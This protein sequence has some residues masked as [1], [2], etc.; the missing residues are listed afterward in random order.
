MQ[1]TTDTDKRKLLSIL[2]HGSIFLS[3]LVISIA[4][5]LGIL[6]ISDDPVVKANAKEA[7]NFHLNVWLYGLL[8]VPL[9]FVTFGLAGGIW[10]LAHWG[11][12][13]WAVVHCLNQPDEPVRY[14]FI[15]RPL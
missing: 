2:S 5:P 3:A 7:L 11:L 14:P 13:L 9:S 10:W 15:F 1:T 12:T 6:I 4:I 8:L